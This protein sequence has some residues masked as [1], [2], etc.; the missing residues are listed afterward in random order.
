M[1]GDDRAER[2]TAAL[3]AFWEQEAGE[4]L[5][6]LDAFA[7]TRDS[8]V[9]ALLPVVDEMCREAAADELEATA[10]RCTDVHPAGAVAAARR[11]AQLRRGAQ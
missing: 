8:Y 11:A 2:L 7:E 10:E 3:T 6:D 1:T 9:A 5:D 4:P